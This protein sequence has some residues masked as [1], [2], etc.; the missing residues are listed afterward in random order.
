MI[1]CGRLEGDHVELG[2]RHWNAGELILDGK[3]QY[4]DHPLSEMQAPAETA[5]GVMSSPDDVTALLHVVR[6][7]VVRMT[8]TRLLQ[9]KLTLTRKGQ[10]RD[11]YRSRYVEDGVAC[12]MKVNASTFMTGTFVTH[13]LVIKHR[14]QQ[15]QVLNYAIELRK[16][17]LCFQLLV[18]YC[19]ICCKGLLHN[20]T[21]YTCADL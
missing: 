1:T 7:T 11:E 16:I 12:D 5:R 17:K 21:V 3:Y 18:Q 13:T 10:I 6:M 4:D 8:C 9:I 20:T 15:Q 19:V 2:Q 14:K